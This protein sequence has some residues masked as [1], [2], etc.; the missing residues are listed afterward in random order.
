MK[1]FILALAILASASLV[2]VSVIIIRNNAS[3]SEETAIIDELRVGRYYLSGGTDEQYIE[4]FPDKTICM[5]GFEG[6]RSD[7]MSLFESR[8]SYVIDDK[9]PF[10][11]LDDGEHPPVVGYGYCGADMITFSDFGEE[12]QYVYRAAETEQSSA[13]PIT[14]EASAEP[15]TEEASVAETV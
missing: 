3:A 7:I 12:R 14:E 2:A 13:E 10:I 15:V 1:K 6:E 9:L 4:V 11:G 8:N 5:Y